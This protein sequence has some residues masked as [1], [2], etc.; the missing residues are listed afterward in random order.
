[1]LAENTIADGQAETRARRDGVQDQDAAGKKQFHQQQND[2]LLKGLAGLLVAAAS[3]ILYFAVGE[4]LGWPV[5]VV[6]GL[7][8]FYPFPS[9]IF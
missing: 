6:A 5:L 3:A 8:L 2:S 4:E 9:R 1:M 7:F